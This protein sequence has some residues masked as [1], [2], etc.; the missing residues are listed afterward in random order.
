MLLIHMN[1]V[2]FSPRVCS[3]CGGKP[4][5]IPQSFFV[6]VITQDFMVFLAIRPMV[7]A[8]VFGIVILFSESQSHMYNI[9][10]GLDVITYMHILW[11]WCKL[12]STICLCMLTVHL[13]GYFAAI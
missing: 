1:Y 10:D 9:I 3:H 5:F 11:S 13:N 8:G 7:Q 4:F 6:F 2:G 12:R